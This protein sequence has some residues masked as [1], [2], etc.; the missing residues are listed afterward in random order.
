MEND[1]IGLRVDPPVATLTLNRPQQGNALTR[2][3]L[4]EMRVALEDVH[5][6]KRVRAVVLTG[7]GDAFC[8]GRDLQELAAAGEDPT[9]DQRR[10]GD[11]A[12]EYR[13]LLA[14]ML[15]LPKPIVAAVNGPAEAGGAGLVLACDIVV[16]CESARFGFPEPRRGVVAGVAAPLLA[17]RLGA[18]VAARLLL[19]SEVVTAAEALRI[20]V[21][22]ELH[23]DEVLWARAVE[24]G[25]QAATAAPEAVLLTKR[26]LSETIGEQLPTQLTSGAIA[27]AMARTTEAAQEGLRAHLEQ[28]E[29]EW[30]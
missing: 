10:W 9:D 7:R 1:A 28:R 4:A 11:E 29:P 14:A 17:W 13:D 22:H 27:S 21:Y 3:M 19:S 26:V 30:P 24:I 5:R 16:A 20:G 6:E 25:K 15:E 23:A 18:G 2:S 12:S 8:L